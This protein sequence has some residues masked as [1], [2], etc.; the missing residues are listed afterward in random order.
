MDLYAALSARPHEV[1]E[2]LIPEEL[3]GREYV[4]TDPQTAVFLETSGCQIFKA[5]EDHGRR[6]GMPI[7]P[8][9]PLRLLCLRIAMVRFVC[10]VEALAGDDRGALVLA[11][12]KQRF[13][14]HP[15]TK[16]W[17]SPV[18]PHVWKQWQDLGAVSSEERND[19]RFFQFD[20]K[21]A[22]QKVLAQPEWWAYVEGSAALATTEQA[23]DDEQGLLESF[24]HFEPRPIMAAAR[25]LPVRLEVCE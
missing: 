6:A 5:P 23:A 18:E 15:V 17:L 7:V 16:K 14:Q 1:P 20:W 8:Y 24:E 19:L 11:D 21:K 13:L 22:L 12:G 4:Y 25:L 2:E 3:R 10:R 9:E